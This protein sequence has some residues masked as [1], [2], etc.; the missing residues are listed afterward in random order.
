MAKEKKKWHDKV[1]E[2]TIKNLAK[3]K[4]KPA[5]PEPKMSE[6]EAAT[7]VPMQPD[8]QVEPIY[9]FHYA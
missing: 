4:A 6:R 2:K 1:I 8:P 3:E 7:V 5:A 9:R